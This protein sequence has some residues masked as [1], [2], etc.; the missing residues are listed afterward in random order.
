MNSFVYYAPVK[1][2]FGQCLAELG[3][4]AALYGKRVLLIS[5]RASARKSGLYDRIIGILQEAGLELFELSGVKP[6]PEIDLV[7]KAGELCKSEEIDL[8]IGIGGGSVMDTAKWTAAAAYADFDPWLFFSRGKRVAKA[9]P[10]IT[11]PTTAATGSETNDNGVI[12]NS[13]TKDKLSRSASAILPKAAFLD[14]ENTFT[15]DAFQTACGA[16]DMFSHILETYFSRDE[17]LF[18]LDLLMEG[19]LKT[20]VRYS[21]AAVEIPNDYEA[22]ANLMWTA[23]WAINGLISSGKKQVWSCHP[24]EHELSALYDMTHGPGLAVLMPKWMKYVL[25]EKTAERFRRF[26]CQVFGI[27]EDLPVM[28]AAEQGILRTEDFL[29]RE[30]AFPSL[31]SEEKVHRK[32]FKMIA[33]KAVWNGNLKNAYEPLQEED[34]I[35]VL[36]ACMQEDSA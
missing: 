3:K 10:V 36:E 5:G 18:M 30:L 12:S 7:R 1:I 23:G 33:K 16:A 27:S 34:V 22:R 21:T 15:L 20:I 26:A 8:V 28:A 17:G 35:A 24:V 2:F 11:V 19:M 13:V 6:N 31:F 4:E 32:D 14:P 9:L 29:Y 25:N